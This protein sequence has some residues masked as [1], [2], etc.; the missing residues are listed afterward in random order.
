MKSLS[1]TSDSITG[2][3]KRISSKAIFA[4]VFYVIMPIFSITMMILTYPQLSKER[5]LGILQRTVPIGILLILVSQ[6]QVRY[7]K[8]DLGR[9][10][11]NEIY[12]L[13]VVL[14]IFA[15]LG[16]QPVL[17]QTWEEYHFSLHIWNYVVVIL[18]V[19]SMN[20][21][22]YIFEYQAYRN[23]E[24]EMENKDTDGSEVDGTTAQHKGVT[25]ISVS[26]E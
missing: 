17:H 10:V 22:Y 24:E 13:L 5:L 9:F 2:K 4:L 11:L 1:K 15:L 16:G 7:E 18:I 19:T 6:Y 23:R 20:F 3:Q 25:I 12:I 26:S 14:W 21:L 8:G